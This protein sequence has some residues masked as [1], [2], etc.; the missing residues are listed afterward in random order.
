MRKLLNITAEIP[1]RLKDADEA[2][3]LY[4]RWA[5]DRERRRHCASAEGRYRIPPGEVDREPR[6][7]ILPAPDAMAI[8]RALLR[9]PDKER[10]VLHILYVPKRQPPEMQLRLLRIPP[11][12][13]AQ[14]HLDGLRMFANLW[15]MSAHA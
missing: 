3:H 1:P 14:R 7:V 15:A 12:L 11:Q 5:M 13:S 8:H 10:I 6:E 4:G 9:V 2:L